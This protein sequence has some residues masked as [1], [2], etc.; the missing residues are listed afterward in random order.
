MIA[1]AAR[2]NYRRCCDKSQ[3]SRLLGYSHGK[4]RSSP[5]EYWPKSLRDFFCMHYPLRV[6]SFF[7]CRYLPGGTCAIFQAIAESF[8]TN[9][10]IPTSDL[11]RQYVTNIV[12]FIALYRQIY[13]FGC[14][15]DKHSKDCIWIRDDKCTHFLKE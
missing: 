10:S 6:K 14:P 12:L 4:P 2:G 11:Y 13:F 7:V 5:C 8:E 9:S 1:N 3:Q 15:P